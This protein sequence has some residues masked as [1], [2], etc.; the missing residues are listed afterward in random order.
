[1]PCPCSNNGD[2]S[3]VG[4]AKKLRKLRKLRT[5]EKGKAGAKKNGAVKSPK[6]RTKV[7]RKG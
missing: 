3:A 7:V 5:A 2:Y 1:M 4:G 6:K